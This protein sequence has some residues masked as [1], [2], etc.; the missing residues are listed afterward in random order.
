MSE[1][2]KSLKELI[3][4]LP[5]GCTGYTGLASSE[6]VIAH[7]INVIIIKLESKEVNNLNP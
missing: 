3:I 4:P 6:R 2:I 7:K 1:L 5:K